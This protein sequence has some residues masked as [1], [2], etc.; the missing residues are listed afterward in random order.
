M[1][2]IKRRLQER[3][4]SNLINICPLKQ[5]NGRITELPTRIRSE[6]KIEASLVLTMRFNTKT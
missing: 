1:K 4:N 5:K 3:M 6:L 2:N